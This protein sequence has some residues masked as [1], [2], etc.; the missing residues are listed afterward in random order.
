MVEQGGEL[1]LLVPSCCLPHT[2]QPLGHA[3]PALC[4]VRAELMSVLLDQRPSLPTL[5]GLVVVFVRMVH[6]YYAA[7]RLLRDVRTGLTALAFA[8]RPAAVS[9]TGITEVSRFS[10]MKSPD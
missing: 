8:R 10:C 5:R 7:V 3:F 4:R 6:R 2:R 1:Q 9:S